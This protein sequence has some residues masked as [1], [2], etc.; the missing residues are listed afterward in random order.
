MRL[1][2][3]TLLALVALAIVA[4]MLTTPREPLG[5][6]SIP[7][8]PPPTV[9]AAEPSAEVDSGA[10][11]TPR[12]DRVDASQDGPDLQI[13]RV[14][15]LSGRTPVPGV[16]IRLRDETGTRSCVTDAEGRARFPSCQPGTPLHVAAEC[17]QG[18]LLGVPRILSSSSG[19]TTLFFVESLR[20]RG[21]V[22]QESGTAAAGAR[23]YV[24][25]PQ[26]L[27]QG[28]P[29]PEPRELGRTDAAGLFDVVVA[30]SLPAGSSLVAELSPWVPAI[31]RLDAVI[32]SDTRHDLVLATGQSWT[33]LMTDAS[34]RPMPGVR[35][36]VVTTDSPALPGW[37]AEET[38]GVGVVAR[39]MESD[40]NGLAAVGNWP[41]GR[42]A[43]IR[44]AQSDA[45]AIL[46]SAVDDP[47]AVVHSRRTSLEI[48]PPSAGPSAVRLLRLPRDMLVVRGVAQGF[49][50]AELDHLYLY[51]L[52]EGGTGLRAKVEPGEDGAF[53][54][55]MGLLQVP[56]DRTDDI[57][58]RLEARI[59]D[60]PGTDWR[61]DVGLFDLRGTTLVEGVLVQR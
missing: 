18:F 42:R 55:T 59:V 60:L 25:C 16:T 17:A 57:R 14:C 10:V 46:I 58:M 41:T 24:C 9:V 31:E 11:P 48:D 29:W 4:A 2:R 27:D 33:M 40:S 54:V 47:G 35:L 51:K 3:N 37:H 7:I 36:T 13:V 22:R 61:R 49:S 32:D 50:A 56:G 12:L 26:G 23:I 30:G 21:H 5:G 20:L 6:P 34:G 44:I 43:C 8:T 15:T 52:N 53:E 38:F 1:L 28:R 39:E 19:E 45:A